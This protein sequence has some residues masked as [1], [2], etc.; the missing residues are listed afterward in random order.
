MIGFN[1]PL[2]LVLDAALLATVSFHTFN[3]LRILFFDL[4]MGTK[5]QKLSFVLALVF[6]GIIVMLAAKLLVPVIFGR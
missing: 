4:G 1:Q 5:R 6:T 3:G 2:F